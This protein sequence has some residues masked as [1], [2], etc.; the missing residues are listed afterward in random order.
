[1]KILQLHGR[2]AKF[3]GASVHTEMLINHLLVHDHE[4]FLVI[5]KGNE[6]LR[7]CFSKHEKVNYFELE[8]ESVTNTL[9]NLIFLVRF[10]LKYKIEI[11]HSHHRNADILACLAGLLVKSVSVFP[12]LHGPY[13]SPESLMQKIVSN[14][15]LKLLN[16]SSKKIAYISEF[17]RTTFCNT[18]IKNKAN[19]VIHNGS[20]KPD[21]LEDHLYKKLIKRNKFAVT[22][23]CNISGYKRVDLLLEI[24]EHLKNIKDIEFWV[25][26]DGSDKNQL[27]TIAKQKKLNVI[28]WGWSRDV[29]GYI[30]ASN[31]VVS[32]AINEGFGRTLTEALSHGKPIISFESGGPVEIISDHKN[33]Y[34]IKEYDTKSFAFKINELHES[35]ILYADFS[36]NAVLAWEEKFSPEIFGD[37]Y[38]G[39]F[40]SN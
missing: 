22:L 35:K 27:E 17:V 30:S 6:Y 39:L 29:G 21:I 38:I 11:I 5:P 4:V 10:L 40:C 26:G 36:K 33:G 32:T 20:V 19:K 1:M 28:F 8:T 34:L 15:H 18:I 31:I 9:L 7:E 3:G 25:V 2:S 16:L 12:T 37:N 23:L 24:A 13:I 14:V